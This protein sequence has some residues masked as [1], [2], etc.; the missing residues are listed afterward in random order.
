MKQLVV[1]LML[2]TIL[3]G[4]GTPPDTVQESQNKSRPFKTRDTGID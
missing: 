4:C 2:G 1:P 3:S